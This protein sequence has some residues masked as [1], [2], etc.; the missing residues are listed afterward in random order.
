N[1]RA[2]ERVVVG[3]GHRQPRRGLLGVARDDRQTLIGQDAIG[4]GRRAGA[5]VERAARRR[6]AQRLVLVGELLL[7]QALDVAAQLRV[8]LLVLGRLLE[9]IF[10]ARSVQRL[11][12]GALD[13]HAQRRAAEVDALPV[14]LGEPD[15]D[16]RVGLVL[17]EPGRNAERVRGDHEGERAMP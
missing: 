13:L 9:R 16:E 6:L 5:G 1:A 14:A 8:V 17:D 11:G 7:G 4:A 2:A 3:A 12:T 15:L 10:A